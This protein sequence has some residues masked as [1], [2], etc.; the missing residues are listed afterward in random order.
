MQ[1]KTPMGENCVVSPKNSH[2]YNLVYSAAKGRW[3]KNATIAL[4]NNGYVDLS[5]KFE[6][7]NSR[8]TYNYQKSLNNLVNRI[9]NILK[10][11]EN[12]YTIKNNNNMYYIT[13][14]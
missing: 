8:K 11:N 4:L 7:A 14:N 2:M 13:T 12:L 1:R 9:N 3:Q 5:D 10:E 6:R